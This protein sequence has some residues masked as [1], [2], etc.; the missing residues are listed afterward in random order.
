MGVNEMMNEYPCV[1]CK[2][3]VN[4][5]GFCPA[6][7]EWFCEIWPIV[8]GKKVDDDGKSEKE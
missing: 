3:Q 8:T 2:Q 1:K 6:W 4:C 5:S 7:K